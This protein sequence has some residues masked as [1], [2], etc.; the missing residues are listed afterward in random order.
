MSLA[1]SVGWT[2]ATLTELMRH[3]EMMSDYELDRDFVDC[4]IPVAESEE[5]QARLM[6]YY[7]ARRKGPYWSPGKPGANN[8]QHVDFWGERARKQAGKNGSNR[9]DKVDRPSDLAGLKTAHS[10]SQR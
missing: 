5:D 7:Q 2:T 4:L 6:A 10:G 1:F 8:G 3:A 9:A